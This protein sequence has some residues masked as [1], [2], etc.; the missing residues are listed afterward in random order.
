M[1]IY[2]I[3]KLYDQLPFGIL[4]TSKDDNILYF[5]EAFLELTQH[6]SK[7]QLGNPINKVLT[8]INIITDA[9]ELIHV[10]VKVSFVVLNNISFNCYAVSN[11]TS[12]SM[13]EDKLQTEVERM[14]EAKKLAKFGH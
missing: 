1:N 3:A 6:S 4:L 5:N 8:S 9:N 7:C 2:T 14:N 13:L 11:D 10:A 12:Q